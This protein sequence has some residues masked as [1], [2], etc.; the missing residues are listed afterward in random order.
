MIDNF[1]S[2]RMT[3][4]CRPFQ[5]HRGVPMTSVLDFT[6]EKEP[7]KAERGPDTSLKC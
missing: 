2:V 1:D 6:D 3:D 7:V 4:G 5:D